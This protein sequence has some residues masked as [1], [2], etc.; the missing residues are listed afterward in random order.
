MK[1]KIVEQTGQ[2]QASAFNL[3]N[4]KVDP[5]GNLTGTANI[6]INNTATEVP[7]NVNV[8]DL[9]TTQG[10]NLVKNAKILQVMQ[11][12]TAGTQQTQQIQQKQQQS[13]VQQ[14]LQQ[15]TGVR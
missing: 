8:V 7:I 9:L 14:P 6:M 10:Q 3:Q 15:P 12:L 5:N 11:N 13:Q 4:A 2:M 1:F